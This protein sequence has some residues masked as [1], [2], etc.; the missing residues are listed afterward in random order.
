MDMGNEAKI[1]VGVIAGLFVI[2]CVVLVVRLSGGKAKPVPPVAASYDAGSA[3]NSTASSDLAAPRLLNPSQP[4][5]VRASS[6]STTVLKSPVSAGGWSVAGDSS[7]DSGGSGSS[8]A[9]TPP[10]LM[11]NPQTSAVTATALT[12]TENAA[13]TTIPAAASETVATATPTVPPAPT[14][15]T[16]STIAT[17]PLVAPPATA[18]VSTPTMSAVPG[19]SS[20]YAS[21][22]PYDPNQRS[23]SSVGTSNTWGSV[24]APPATGSSS[25][26][27]IVGGVNSAPQAYSSPSSYAPSSG[28]SASTSTYRQNRY[29]YGSAS[30]PASST[31]PPSGTNIPDA[32]TLSGSATTTSPASYSGR[33]DDG[34]YKVRPNDN[35]WTI[36]EKLYGSGAYFKALAEVNRDR[37]SRDDRLRVGTV[38]QAPA[39]EE[40]EKNYPDLCPKANHRRAAGALRTV[41]VSTMQGV[42][43]RVY[44]VEQGDTLIDIARRQ[45]GKSSRWAEILELNR[46]KLG[47]D[48]DYLLPGMQL[49]M[50]EPS[51]TPSG[52]RGDMLTERPGSNYRR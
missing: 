4:T 27:S 2:L 23:G 52:G 49:A 50:P 39:A 11:P 33:R 28:T 17:P 46:D 24:A 32:A 37:T 6:T 42:G 5:I 26:S 43:R 30:D 38:L 12:V 48:H 45:L 13:P 40:L 51:A 15:A 34:T 8:L 29:G 44:T 9:A 19:P 21:S 35:Y 36:S 3:A 18:S 41:S 31:P 20:P 16:S 14:M 10:S 22:T 25:P 1:G 7:T 47:E